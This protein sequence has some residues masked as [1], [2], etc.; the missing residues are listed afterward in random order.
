VL[1]HNLSLHNLFKLEEHKIAVCHPLNPW[2]FIMAVHN[3]DGCVSFVTKK[4][5]DSQRIKI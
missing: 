5:I 2:N 3:T 1:I 4:A